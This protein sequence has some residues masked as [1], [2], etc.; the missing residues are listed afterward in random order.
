MIAPEIDPVAI[1]IGPLKVHWYG[2]MYLMG[3]VSSWWVG[4]WRA[5]HIDTTWKPEEVGDLIFYFA[6]AIII[7]GRLGYVVFYNPSY[8]LS[9]PL[10]VFYIWTGGM[11]FHGGLLGV[12]LAMWLYARRI[13]QPFFAVTDF[14]VIWVPPGLGL[15]RIGNFING[16]LFAALKI[17]MTLSVSSRRLT[18]LL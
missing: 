6:L 17:R 16:E 14:M 4:Q 11:S 3:F 9:H 18:P 8:Y 10:E 12:L 7:G 5:K 2:L 15:V 1:K 13:G